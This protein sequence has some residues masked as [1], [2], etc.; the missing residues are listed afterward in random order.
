[1][2]WL[3]SPGLQ[4]T[5]QVQIVALA[6]G[7]AI[8]LVEER[9]E[10]HAEPFRG[11]PTVAPGFVQSGGD[12]STL[13]SLD[14]IPQGPRLCADPGLGPGV[15]TDPGTLRDAVETAERRAIA[16]ALNEAGGN[17]RA[18]AKR[19]GVSLRTLFYKMDRYAID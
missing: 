7:V 11:R 2:R 4:I 15:S 1:M 17:R 8:H 16:A 9:S 13:R 6:D 3:Q 12:R 18:A 5:A 10:A 14:R 19:L